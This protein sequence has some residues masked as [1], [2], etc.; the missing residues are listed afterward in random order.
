MLKN[1]YC[2]NKHW[3]ASQKKCLTEPGLLQ[4]TVAVFIITAKQES[5]AHLVLLDMMANQDYKVG[6][7]P[8]ST[9]IT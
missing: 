1:I 9:S 3:N 7:P 8:N 6:M 5:K 4:I 2:K